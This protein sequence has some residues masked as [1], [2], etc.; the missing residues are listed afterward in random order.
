MSKKLINEIIFNVSIDSIDQ[1]FAN[2]LT[3]VLAKYPG[4]H[5]LKFNIYEKDVSLNLLSK[6]YRVNICTSFIQD[7]SDFAKD[8]IL[9]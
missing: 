1:N 3:E 8:F 7:M 6:K 2:S 5:N 9:K 4:K